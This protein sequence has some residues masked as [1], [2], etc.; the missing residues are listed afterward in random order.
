MQCSMQVIDGYRAVSRHG[1]LAP[2][3]CRRQRLPATSFEECASACLA[4]PFCEAATWFG[5]D[6]AEEK[7]REVCM[8]RTGGSPA[9]FEVDVEARSAM[10]TCSMSGCGLQAQLN[11]RCLAWSQAA[12]APPACRSST[13]AR[14]RR[15]LGGHDARTEDFDWTCA[16]APSAE[17]NATALPMIMACV[18]DRGNMAPCHS[19]REAKQPSLSC[20]PGTH[21]GMPI[22]H[23]MHRAGCTP[24]PMCLATPGSG[25]PTAFPAALPDATDPPPPSLPALPHWVRRRGVAGGS[26]D[27]RLAAEEAAEEGRDGAGGAPGGGDGQGASLDYRRSDGASSYA[28]AFADAASRAARVRSSSSGRR[29]SADKP[30]RRAMGAGG[31]AEATVRRLYELGYLNCS[32]AYDELK[33]GCMAMRPD[34]DWLQYSWAAP[35]GAGGAEAPPATP[36]SVAAQAV[37]WWLPAG[38]VGGADAFDADAFLRAL[39]RLGAERHGGKAAGEGARAD[40]EQEVLFVGD[41][42]ARQQTVSL[43]CLLTAGAAAAGGAFRVVV[44]K[45]V[46]YMDFK[47]RVYTSTSRNRPVA[48]VSFLRFMRADA[49]PTWRPV[50]RT[51]KLSPVLASAVAKRPA[52]LILNLGAWEYEDGCNDMHSLHDAL[53]NATR[54]WIMREYAS[55]WM[56]LASA[57]RA[58]YFSRGRA[59]K[60]AVVVW[61]AAT[62]RDFEGGVAKQ[63][64]RCRRHAP[65]KPPELGRLETHLDPASMRFAVL[66]KNVIMDAVAMQRAPWVHILDAYGIARQRADAHPGPDPKTNRQGSLHP[67]AYDDC[68]HYCLPGVPD[69]YNG[70]LLSLLER[71]VSDGAPSTST[72]PAVAATAAATA[73]PAEGVPGALLARWNF[74]FGERKFVQGALASGG[75]QLQFSRDAP[76]T[77]LECPLPSANGGAYPPATRAEPLAGPPLLGFCSDFDTSSAFRMRNATALGGKAKAPRGAGATK[78]RAGLLETL[79]SEAGK[80]RRATLKEVM[81]RKER[82]S[83]KATRRNATA[84]RRNATGGGVMSGL[85]GRLGGRA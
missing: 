6:A 43:C 73:A 3:D 11:A 60:G 65:I 1:F 10:R 83:L 39:A 54:P 51:P 46:P 64:G 53:C 71:A 26:V 20:W 30:K 23:D 4:Q 37:S 18:D 35:K 5:T 16:P 80:A 52:V 47:C 40:K 8:G 21:G 56:L 31:G 66:T 48:S 72:A 2:P 69:L 75:L 67:R 49:L 27:A 41:S 13:V 62:P 44:T 79:K 28:T 14:N 17:N 24:P 78:Q 77:A 76:S 29:L 74:G 58:S 85:L 70:R 59:A 42:T 55:K 32:M 15:V 38:G 9:T 81:T 68:L 50:E 33:D 82:D 36:P 45:A 25:W 22:M 84:T 57:L 19:V 7:F 34:W 12:K 63:G 61:R